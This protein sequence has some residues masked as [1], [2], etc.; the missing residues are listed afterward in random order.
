[1]ESIRLPRCSTS[2]LTEVHIWC[3]S[4]HSSQTSSAMEISL[5]VLTKN[6]KKCLLDKEFTSNQNTMRNI[7]T[8]KILS[9]RRSFQQPFIKKLTMIERS[10]QEW[11]SKRNPM[12]LWHISMFMKLLT[13][14]NFSMLSF[15]SRFDLTKK[16][17][18]L[19]EWC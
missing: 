4:I 19:K 16:W 6:H 11:E 15:K 12:I 9:S 17:A 7:M 18:Q 14:S 13:N 3:R 10:F 8:I 1:M 2:M 5:S